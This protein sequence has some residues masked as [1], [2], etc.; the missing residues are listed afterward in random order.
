MEPNSW[1]FG[2]LPEL[3]ADLIL[4][5][6]P[7]RFRTWSE[8]NQ[9]KSASKHYSLMEL[10]DI[11]RLQVN[12]LAQKDCL[13]LMWGIFAMLPQC[14][15]VMAAWGFTY[16]SALAWRKTTASGKVRWGTGYWARSM[17]EPVLIG[18]L[19]K[20]RVKAF[21]SLFDGIA[22][23][24]SRKPDEFFALVEKYAAPASPVELFARESR[25]NW[26]SWGNETRKFNEAAE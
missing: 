25:P 7:W 17:H 14:L 6:P 22:R 26:R 2:D 10:A 5:D 4:A 3:S 21:P 24:H 9:Q 15:E 16:K 12:R 19:G 13:L 1:P 20:P 11:K 8:T 18:T 23:E